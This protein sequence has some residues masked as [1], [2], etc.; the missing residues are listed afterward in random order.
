PNRR[1]CN[2]QPVSRA[3]YATAVPVQRDHSTTVAFAVDQ[4]Q[5]IWSD[6]TGVAPTP[7]FHETR[8]LRQLGSASPRR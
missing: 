8:T 7:P 1:D 5:V 4:S 3:Y 2:G 6:D